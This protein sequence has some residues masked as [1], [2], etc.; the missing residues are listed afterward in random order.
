MKLNLN[1]VSLFQLWVKLADANMVL[2]IYS[3][4]KLLKLQIVNMQKEV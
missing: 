2:I 3:R 4:V 1:E